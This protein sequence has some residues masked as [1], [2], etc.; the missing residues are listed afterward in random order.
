LF[1]SSR[2]AG[3][4]LWAALLGLGCSSPPPPRPAPKVEVPV[5]PEPPDHPVKWADVAGFYGTQCPPPSFTLDEP[6]TK[7]VAGQTFTVSG[8]HAA[9]AERQ[10]GP[11][12]IG[13]LGAVKD[14][15]DDTKKNLEVAKAA[16]VA[17]KV[18]LIVF[19]GDVAETAEIHE[20]ASMIGDVFG[21]D[22]PL[23]VHSGNSEWT[24]GFTDAFADAEAAHPA[25]FNMNFIRH[26]D[27]GGVHLVSLP[28]WSVREFVKQG[29]CHYESKHVEELTTLVNELNAKGE[30]VVLTA[31]G[32]P[33]GKDAASL[34]RTFDDGNVGDEDLARLLQSG[35]VRFG[36]F[37]H[38]LEAGGRATADA[39]TH[40][41]LPLPQKKPSP[42]LF[43]NV[44]SA[45]S[46]GVELLSKKTSRGIAAVVTIDKLD[47]GG[48][49]TVKFVPLK[50]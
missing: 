10:Q 38:I 15:A 17:A 40:K 8:T 20:V 50:K 41:P 49:A 35:A 33:R 5:E 18:S 12:V 6:L 21:D 16:F 9:R 2:V 42:S 45:S 26:L 24:S 43:V 30:V 34:D 1:S 11:L 3:V 47:A 14:A 37:G 36:L 7:T 27:L 25:F 46:V 28:G 39:T 29:G 44:G 23:I 31:H 32:P 13:V 4:A 22:V 48:Q 19:N